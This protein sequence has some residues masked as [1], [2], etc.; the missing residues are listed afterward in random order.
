MTWARPFCALALGF[1]AGWLPVWVLPTATGSTAPQALE[2]I[3]HWQG[4]YPVAEL[5]RLPED[6]GAVRCGALVTAAQFHPVWQAL[7]PERAAPDIDFCRRLVVFC[8]NVCFYNRLSVAGVLLRGETAEVLTRAT[9][10]ALPIEDRVAMALAVIPRAG[11]SFA[12]SENGGVRVP[13]VPKGTGSPLNASY[14]IEGA[15]TPLTKGR[16]ENTAMPGSAIKTRTSIAGGPRYGDLDGDGACDAAIVIVHDHGGSGTFYYIAAAL[17]RGGRC[18]GTNAVLLGDRIAL[19]DPAKIG[20][21]VI[22]VRYRGRQAQEPMTAAPSVDRLTVVALDGERLVPIRLSAPDEQIVTG[23]VTIG[24][25]ARTFRPTGQSAEYWL[26][27]D[28]PAMRQ[29]V[30]RHAES[31]REAA[32]YTPVFMVLTGRFGDSPRDGF[33]AAYASSFRPKGVWAVRP[34]ANAIQ[35]KEEVK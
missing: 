30:S 11:V 18:R 33:G 21:G 7:M 29:I 14:W 3:D 19:R 10:S 9:L 17:N 2:I 22:T 32:P 25:E 13:V 15:W 12:G 28:S 8:R 16:A 23:W 20:D 24:H 27:G 4:D 6:Q 26:A 35:K 1:L 31:T 34:H 5:N